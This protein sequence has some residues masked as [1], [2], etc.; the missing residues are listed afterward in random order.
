LEDDGAEVG[1]GLDERVGE[2]GGG[3]DAQELGVELG[4]ALEVKVDGGLLALGGELGDE[5][6]AV[7]GEEGFDGGGLGGVGG[8]SCG[9][10]G[11]IA[12]REALVHLLVDAAGVLGIRREVLGAA[13]EFEE[14]EDGVAVAVGGGARGKRAVAV[15]EGAAAEAVGGVDAR[16][17][18]P[19]G[20]A[21]EE[22]RVQAQAAAGLGE[23]EDGGGGAIE[24]ER[25]LELGAGDGVVDAGYASAEV[26]ALGLRVGR[27]EDAGDAAAEVGG[28]GEVRLVFTARAVQGEDSGESGDG[29]QSF[30]GVLGREGYGV[31]EVEGR[32]HRRIVDGMCMGSSG[33]AFARC[34]HLRIE[35]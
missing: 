1:D 7:G 4:G 14:V 24:R 17:G 23:A 26:E 15:G 2:G 27:R 10:A 11:L 6:L 34:P 18:V 35:I 33:R 25:G 21:E 9:R 28:A 31:L 16:V 32:S 29:T 13:A 20:E 12:G 3:L 30:G 19:G 8:C 22:G 5:G